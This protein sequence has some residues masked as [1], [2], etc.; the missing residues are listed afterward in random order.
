[1]HSVSTWRR[2]LKLAAAG[3]LMTAGEA[4][5][6]PATLPVAVTDQGVDLASATPVAERANHDGLRVN[7]EWL[8]PPL[9]DLPAAHERVIDALSS[10]APIIKRT[11]Q[12]MGV[13]EHVAGTLADMRQSGDLPL[14]VAGQDKSAWWQQRQP[15]VEAVLQ[16]RQNQN[17]TMLLTM[18]AALGGLGAATYGATLYLEHR[19]RREQ[20]PGV[21]P[22]GR[23]G[24]PPSGP[25]GIHPPD[26]RS[27][28]RYR[29]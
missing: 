15:G 18:L 26:R 12:D 14:P 16:E 27:P 4:M 2:D 7:P 11:L 20:Q 5:A 9:R 8:W 6:S 3:A 13:Y 23:S 29:N 17:Q 21:A 22:H 24:A 10:G 25:V 28:E 1:M 19:L